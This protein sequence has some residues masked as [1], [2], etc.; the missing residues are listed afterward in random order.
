MDDFGAAEASDK[1][2]EAFEELAVV[3]RDSGLQE[4]V[5]KKC[6]PN[7]TMVFLGIWFETEN[8]TL[9]VTEERMLEIQQLLKT[10]QQKVSATHKE[11]QK[12]IG[13]KLIYVA[14]CFRPGKIFL[15]LACWEFLRSFNRDIVSRFQKGCGMVGS[16]SAWLQW[17]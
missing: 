11:V 16:I 1:A 7:I 9:S 17:C 8:L 10:W 3:I 14:K 5:E 2:E 13:K 4:S 12:L 15:F 6:P